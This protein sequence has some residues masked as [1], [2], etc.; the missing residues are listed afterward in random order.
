MKI[1]RFVLLAVL[2]S[3]AGVARAESSFPDYL[4]WSCSFSY[5]DGGQSFQFKPSDGAAESRA[6]AHVARCETLKGDAADERAACSLIE[7][8]PGTPERSL[9]RKAFDPAGGAE[10]SVEAEPSLRLVCRPNS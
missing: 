9:A 10:L 5:A 7:A 4:S 2:A 8:R 6:G 3:A 1:T